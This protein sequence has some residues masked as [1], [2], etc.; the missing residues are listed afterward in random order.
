M[1]PRSLLLRVYAVAPLVPPALVAVDRAEWLGLWTVTL[2]G[3]GMSTLT[4]FSSPAHAA[5]L[6]RVSG[7]SVQQGVTASTVIAFLMQILGLAL[8]GQLERIGLLTVLIVQAAS[9]S[10]GVLALRR[11]E[12]RPA[13]AAGPPRGRGAA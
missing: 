9:L 10:I 8:A 13:A 1:D 12:A 5:I 7:T 11:I 6:N 4:S 3:L 2:W